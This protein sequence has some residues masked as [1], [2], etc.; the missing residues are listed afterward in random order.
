MTGRTVASVHSEGSLLAQRQRSRAR[1]LCALNGLQLYAQIAVGLALYLY[2]HVSTPGYLSLL[3]VAPFLLLM[4]R[5]GAALVR[6]AGPEGVLA[7]AGKRAGRVLALCFFLVHAADALLLFLALCAVAEDVMPDLGAG[8]GA[9]AMALTLG[10]VLGKRRS[11]EALPRLARLIRWAAA[12]TL[13]FCIVGAF[14]HGSAAHFFPLLG[15]GPFRILQGGLWM[16]G[17]AAGCVSPLLS[18]EN[19]PDAVR[20]MADQRTLLPPLLLALAAGI[21]TMLCSVWLMPVYFMARPETLGWRL[22]VLTNMTPSVPAWS[23]NVMGLFFLLL[24]ALCMSV[25]QA[26]VFLVPAGVSRAASV[27]AGLTALFPA[28]LALPC[29]LAPQ[30]VQRALVDIAPLRAGI[31]LAALLA[32]WLLSRGKAKDTVKREGQS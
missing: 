14:P 16:C 30:A 28:A 24:T 21:V 17:S 8:W 26:A 3:C 1:E 32:L 6:R 27:P 12:L 13:G 2:D 4:G 20:A 31:A 7:L 11:G 18:P 29:I 23:L 15:Y 22:L 25:R 10:L 9:A 5:L 19:D